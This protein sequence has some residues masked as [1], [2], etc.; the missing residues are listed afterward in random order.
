MQNRSASLCA[1]SKT[2][3]LWV[4][5]DTRQAGGVGLGKKRGGRADK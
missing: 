3:A 1:V 2:R 5:K 4:I